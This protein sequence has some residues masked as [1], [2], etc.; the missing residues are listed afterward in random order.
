MMSLRF[1]IIINI[2]SLIIIIQENYQ[3]NM[4]VMIID[5]WVKLHITLSW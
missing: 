1:N 4:H 3:K 5:L 2:L